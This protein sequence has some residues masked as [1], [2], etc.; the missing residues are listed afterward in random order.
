[1]N[2]TLQ[3][4]KALKIEDITPKTR[5]LCQLGHGI[6]TTITRP[7]ST[8]YVI[9][10]YWQNWYTDVGGRRNHYEDQYVDG[11]K[12]E[13]TPMFAV[14]THLKRGIVNGIVIAHGAKKLLSELLD[15]ATTAD[16][17]RP[18]TNQQLSLF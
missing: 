2:V 3:Q 6:Y 9:G 13:I 17:K 15:F 7:Q 14:I 5:I 11:V 18:N 12:G 16:K 4:L 1:M 8:H 10:L